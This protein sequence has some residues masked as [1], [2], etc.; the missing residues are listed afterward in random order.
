VSESVPESNIKES[1]AMATTGVIRRH[2]WKLIGGLLAGYASVL[3][4]ATVFAAEVAAPLP[5]EVVRIGDLNL[6]DSRGVAAAYNRLL[7]AAQR[8]CPGTDSADYWVRESA[9]P[10]VIQA[11]S[12]A[13]DRIGAPQLTAYA[14][15]QPLFRLRGAETIALAD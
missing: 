11:V 15:A 6:R 14:Q 12:R 7:W 3:S 9:A 2:Y 4:V 10:C 5:Q 1:A 8:V 13:I